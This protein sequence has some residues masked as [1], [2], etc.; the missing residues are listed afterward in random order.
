MVEKRAL[1]R[2]RESL[3]RDSTCCN[4]ELRIEMVASG[5]PRYSLLGMG[6]LASTCGVIS[7]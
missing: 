5:E 7:V 1:H 6:H 4:F 3:G 2:R